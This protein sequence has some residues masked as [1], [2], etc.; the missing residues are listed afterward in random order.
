MEN[1]V[2]ER[3][4]FFIKNHCKTQLAFCEKTGISNQHLSTMFYRKSNP[5][6]DVIT[7]IR[8]A[9]PRL[10][11]EWLLFG[12]GNMLLE[13]ETHGGNALNVAAAINNMISEFK[14]LKE[15]ATPGYSEMIDKISELSGKLA[16]YENKIKELEKELQEKEKSSRD[17][18]I[19]ETF[20]ET[21]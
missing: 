5:G 8:M 19:K 21:K 20:P 14:K 6:I 3:L 10:S 13:E 4:R 12:E 17:I 9:Y 7:K 2:N 11:M 15:S 16:V 1:N 18:Q